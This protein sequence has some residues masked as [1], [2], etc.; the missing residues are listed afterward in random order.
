MIISKSRKE[1]IKERG[2]FGS[3]DLVVEIISKGSLSRDLEIKRKLY[4]EY[5]IKEYWIVFPK[6]EFIEI[7][8]L[9]G[10]EYVLYKSSDDSKMLCSKVFKNL[11]VDVEKL[12]K[13]VK[14]IMK[15]W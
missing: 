2:I 11:C 9:E 13:S 7:F 14:K 15:E 12:F 6:E 3:P 5:E 4:A 8:S 10:T 1:M